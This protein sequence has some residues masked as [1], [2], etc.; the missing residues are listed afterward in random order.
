MEKQG[1]VECKFQQSAPDPATGRTW[2]YIIYPNNTLLEFYPE[3]RTCKVETAQSG[4]AQLPADWYPAQAIAALGYQ[5][6]GII[7]GINCSTFYEFHDIGFLAESTQY[8]VSANGVPVSLSIGIGDGPHPPSVPLFQ[9]DVF[10]FQPGVQASAE[11]YR[12]PSYCPNADSAEQ[13]VM[14]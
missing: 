13:A 12:W 1:A 9:A 14:P 5:K 3:A 8:A 2:N 11:H 4:G 7:N 10:Q 6:F